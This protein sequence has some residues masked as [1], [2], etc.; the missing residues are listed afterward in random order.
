MRKKI[1]SILLTLC[2]V[3]TLLPMTALAGTDPPPE[4]PLF[5]GGAGTSGDPYKIATETQLRKLAEL[6]NDQ[7]TDANNSNALYST[8]YY[9]LIEDIGL[10]GEWTP[11]GTNLNPFKGHFDGN[12]HT[13]SGLS[14][15]SSANYLGLFGYTDTDSEIKI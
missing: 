7:R 13:I 4:A 8:L 1:L 6:V 14:I 15:S 10:T 11:I 12:G 2:M 5:V 3:L 9:E